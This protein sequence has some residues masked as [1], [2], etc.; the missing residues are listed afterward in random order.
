MNIIYYIKVQDFLV[1]VCGA[2]EI[3]PGG[4]R[5]VSKSLENQSAVS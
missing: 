3:Q 2:W 1:G 5:V 4:A